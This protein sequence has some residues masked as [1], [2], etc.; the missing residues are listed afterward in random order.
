MKKQTKKEKIKLLK[1]KMRILEIV[2]HKWE[3]ELKD[4]RRAKSKND[5]KK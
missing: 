3:K 2:Y 1:R 5:G 4:L